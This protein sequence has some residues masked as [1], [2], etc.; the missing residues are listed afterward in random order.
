MTLIIKI[1]P[2]AKTINL[3]RIIMGLLLLVSV[4]SF[5]Q[6]YYVYSI[7]GDV[8]LVQGNK[9]K[10][11][12][13]RN[14]LNASETLSMSKGS[15]VV[16]LDMDAK[17]YCTLTVPGKGTISKLLANKQSTTELCSKK[18]WSYLMKQILGKGTLVTRTAHMAKTTGSYRETDSLL[19]MVDSQPKAVADTINKAI[20]K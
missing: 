9:T 17:K 5:S 20:D 8:K 18:Y 15:M 13:V 16:L 4:P 3:S 11:L 2:M 1:I 10:D 6:K 14:V 19:I 12:E 7:R